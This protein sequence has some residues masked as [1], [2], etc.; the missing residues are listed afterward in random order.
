MSSITVIES[1]VAHRWATRLQ[2]VVRLAAIIPA[3]FAAQ[4][5][6]AKPLADIGGAPMVVRVAER[7]ARA[8][9]IDEIAVAT[10]DE[11]IREAVEQAGFRA[12]MTDPLCR[13]GT[14]RIAQAARDLPAE[15]YVNVQGDEPLV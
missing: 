13:N 7:A 3:R 15:G 2:R 11:R 1:R 6:P 10:D 14:E 8:E 4:R 12:I 5:L 9:G